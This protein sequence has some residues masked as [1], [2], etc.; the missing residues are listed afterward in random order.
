MIK[1]L[2][3]RAHDPFII[4]SHGSLLLVC[5]KFCEILF[6]QRKGQEYQTATAVS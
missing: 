2:R 6:P 5:L 1:S 4:I 3:E